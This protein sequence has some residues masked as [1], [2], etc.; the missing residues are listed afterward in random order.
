MHPHY[1]PFPST[2]AA[3]NLTSDL[4]LCLSQEVREKWRR[5]LELVMDDVGALG[6]DPAEAPADG[7]LHLG[8]HGVRLVPR[9]PLPPLHLRRIAAPRR[10]R[11]QPRHPPSRLP[12]HAVAAAVLGGVGAVGRRHLMLRTGWVQER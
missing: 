9:H 12:L 2:T 11:A 5:G 8:L 7:R 6:L 1:I 10:R 4:S 3:S